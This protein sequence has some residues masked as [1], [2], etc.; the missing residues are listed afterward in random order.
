MDRCAAV[1]LELAGLG[2]SNSEMPT[3]SSTLPQAQ[4]YNVL[5]PISFDWT[6]ELLPALRASGMKFDAVPVREWLERLERSDPD[7]KNN[8]SVKLLRFWQEKYGTGESHGNKETVR[9]STVQAQRDSVALREA[10][11]C[12]SSGLVGK[13]VRQWL[14]TWS[15]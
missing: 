6:H 13:F 3:A 8:P 9:F 1:V 2:P 11:D 7:P 5:H 15:V 10:Q 12:I 14:K 4:F